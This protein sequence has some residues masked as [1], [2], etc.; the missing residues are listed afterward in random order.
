MR[1][2]RSLAALGIVAA[3]LLFYSCDDPPPTAAIGTAAPSAAVAAVAQ[4]GSWSDPISW[5]SLAAHMSV[6]PDG[7]VISWTSSD[8]P[9]DQEQHEVHLWNPSSGLF[10]DLSNGTH[11]VFCAGHTFLPDGRLLVGGGHIANNMGVK[12]AKIFNPATNGW[13][14]IPD[15]R[16]GR[17]YPTMTT[18]VNGEVSVVAGA[19]ENASGNP[20]PEVWT[21]SAWRVLGGAPLNMAYYPWMHSAPDGRVFNSGPDSLSWY[22]NPSGSGEWTPAGRSRGGVREYGGSVMYAPGKILIMG[23][24]GPPTNTAEVIDLNTGGGWQLT[25]SMQYRRRQMSSVQLPNGRV[26]AIGGTSGPGFNDEAEAVL[27]T[28]MWDPATGTWTTLASMRTPRLYHSSSVL[29]PDGRVLTSGG[30]RCASCTVDHRDA[31]FFSPPYL[32]AADGSPAPRPTI[33]SAPAS[34]AYGQSFTVASPDAA[35]IARVTWVRLPA[36]THSFNQNHW[37]NELAFTRTATGLTVTAPANAY[38]APPGHYMLFVLNGNGVPS[39]AKA[40]QVTGSALLPPPPPPPAA[41]SALTAVSLNSQQITLA[42][43]DNSTSEVSFHLERCQGAGCT[44]FA[45]I[46]K[47]GPNITRYGDIGLTAGL[48]FNYRIRARNSSGVSGYSNTATA[49]VRAGTAPMGAYIKHELSGRCM[50][51][52]N[53]SQAPA[54]RVVLQ[55]CTG[56][57]PQAWSYPAPGVTGAI[58]VYGFMCLDAASGLGNDGDAIIIW[59]CNGQANQRW[60][61]T[62]SGELRGIN[63]KCIRTID[64]GTANGTGLVIGAC[65]G[66]ASQRWL[67]EPGAAVDQPPFAQFTYSC[68]NLACTFNSGSSSDDGGIASRR[69]DF[70][71]GTTLGDVVTPLKSFAAS[72]TYN[73]TL[74]VTDQSGQSDTEVKAVTVASAP[75]TTTA[76]VHQLSQLCTGRRDGTE[77]N[78]TPIVIEGC[79][80]GTSQSWTMPPAGTAGEIM[81]TGGRCLD[82]AGGGG[83]DGDAIIIWDCNGQANQRWTLTSS[84]ELRGINDKCVDTR[85]GATA[86]G[87]T[88]VLATCTG[89]ASQ[90]WSASTPPAPPEEP[91]ARFTYSCT[92]L[93]CTFDSGGSSDDDGI[94]SR[95]WTFGD[96][97]SAGNVVAPTK[98]YA[99]G[100][101]Y[102]VTLTVTDVGGLTNSL[103]RTVTVTSPPQTGVALV[104]RPSGLC[105]SVLNSSQTKGTTVVIATCA[106][107]TNQR[108][109]LPA[110]G[111][112]GEVRVY[113]SRCLDA[114]GGSGRDGS[115]IIIWECNTGANQMWS[116]TTAGEL[117]GVKGKCVAPKQGATTSGTALELITCSGAASQKW[118]VVNQ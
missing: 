117:K 59:D 43:T 12:D 112:T 115:A 54:T 29:L 96:G 97:S 106:G 30:G 15:M 7:R 56:A 75:P 66:A 85:G 62:S 103:I 57:T 118:D 72:G 65:T 18:L 81:A 91:V 63:D 84:G 90:Q 28:E 1:Y 48:T 17:W 38:V 22:L 87:T 24:G 100:G 10:S 5:P 74:R 13:E 40:V 89:A 69:W 53:G 44:N 27:A 8:V 104:N 71:D 2:P 94:A 58:T 61:L 49:T 14:T 68:T 4:V 51:V 76:L 108:W 36:M 64:G 110:V 78:G 34:V 6:L 47:L 67:F 16:T 3:T 26:L 98:T 32:F 20:F 42:W 37:F 45:E 50:E 101:S 83:N 109:S 105:M 82:A 21:G 70:G 93:N 116:L 102:S 79:L 52:L 86:V 111:V 73:V 80:G 60:T 11:N 113:G 92:Y 23:G 77:T 99:A 114:S 88:L 46:V 31:E 41:P 25:G 35:S 9:G 107:A 95:A 33:T 55:D 39:V 19:D